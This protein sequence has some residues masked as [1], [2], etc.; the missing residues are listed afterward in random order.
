M[1]GR[2]QGWRLRLRGAIWWV[3]FRHEGARY[4]ESTGE[5]DRGEA[6]KQAAK[7]YAGIV[8]G[9][10]QR[11]GLVVAGS[12]SISELAARW[13][14]ALDSTHDRSTITLYQLHL[15]T[16][17]VPFFG[18]RMSRLTTPQIADYGRARLG[19]VTRATVTK[20]RSTLRGFL[21]WCKEQGHLSDLPEW[22]PLPK[23][24]KGVRSTTRKATATHVEPS[25]VARF[26]AA[27]PE[28]STGKLGGSRSFWVRPRIVV[29]WE[30]G[31]RPV[32]VDALRVPEHYTRGV[33]ELRITADIDKIGF[34]RVVPITPACQ[35][36]LDAVAPERGLIFGEH[37]LR[38]YVAMA[39]KAAGLPPGF[40]PYDL[41]HGRI[42]DM[43]ETAGNPVGPAYLVGHKRVTTTAIYIRPHRR[44]AERAL[45]A[46]QARGMPPGTDHGSNSGAQKSKG[47]PSE[48]VD[49][50]VRRAGLE[51]AR[52]Y[53]LAPQ[54]TECLVIAHVSEETAPLKTAGNEA[55][56]ERWERSAPGHSTSPIAD[57]ASPPP[58]GCSTIVAMTHDERVA[59]V[60]GRTVA[61][62]LEDLL[63]PFL[64]LLVRQHGPDAVQ[65]EL[66]RLGAEAHGMAK[67]TSKPWH[68]ARRR[69]R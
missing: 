59:A 63:Y 54:S 19:K 13:L 53:P 5:R 44:A 57:E 50:Q 52:C 49:P 45:E 61:G 64:G 35:A 56:P 48:D 7:I 24:A 68:G 22:P 34:E 17:L 39:A 11:R 26:L 37:D 46:I 4:D 69:S 18:D 67:R 23:Y 32:T 66:A 10:R 55:T 8:A 30:T 9:R 60:E 65:R 33:P 14:A 42:A 28:R 38:D 16:H 40:S 12:G 47:P 43:V 6:E 58:R 25:D 3:R 2:A 36:A 21:D 15:M 51:P 20:E 31:L 41:K 27:L 29:A 1:G 62:V